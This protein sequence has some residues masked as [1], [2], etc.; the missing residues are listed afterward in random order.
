MTRYLD[1]IVREDQVTK[2]KEQLRPHQ[3]ALTAE[4]FTYYQKAVIEHNLRSCNKLYNSI[5]FDELGAILNI[6]AEK[7]ESVAA[8]MIA[9]GR[10]QGSIDQLEKL[11]SFEHIGNEPIL[12]WDNQIESLCGYVNTILD[13]A[14]QRVQ[15]Q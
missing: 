4:G 10:L 2:F 11:V 13:I 3:E 6:S 8:K 9:Q 12:L 1:R 14:Q 5:S 15:A 7:A